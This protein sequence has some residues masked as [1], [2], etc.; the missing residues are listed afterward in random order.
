MRYPKVFIVAMMFLPWL[1]MPFI[2]KQDI[3][4]FYPG[5]IAMSIYLL[6][7]AYV[8][9]NRKWWIFREKLHPKVWGIVPLIFGPF[10]V[11]SIWIFKFTYGR[12]FRY[13]FVNLLIDAFFTYI[14][15]PWFT[16]IKYLSLKKL[17]KFE[18]SIL[19]LVKSIL[20]YGFQYF[21]EKSVN[22]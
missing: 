6:I 20:M 13:L 9:E 12:F 19:F 1:T 16:Q 22:K 8:A 10:F 18:L 5:A 4:R 14:Q 7:E 17:K 15:V 3:R 21:Y 2:G 11:G